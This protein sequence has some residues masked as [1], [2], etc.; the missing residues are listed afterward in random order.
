[1]HVSIN[2]TLLYPTHFATGVYII[3]LPVHLSVCPSMPVSRDAN[4]CFISTFKW[5]FAYGF[6][7]KCRCAQHNFH[8]SKVYRVIVPDWT[9]NSCDVNY[10]TS[11]LLHISVWKFTYTLI[12]KWRCAWHYF[13][14]RS[15]KTEILVSLS[16]LCQALGWGYSSHSEIALVTSDPFPLIIKLSGMMS[17]VVWRA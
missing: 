2:N 1:M 13:H 6:I 17:L 9:Q 15:F 10:L 8:S 4:N 5:K 16:F 14:V 3:R 11:T 7:I 12:I